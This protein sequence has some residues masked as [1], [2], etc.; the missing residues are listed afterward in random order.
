MEPLS[1]IQIVSGIQIGLTNAQ[2]WTRRCGA[3]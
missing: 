2:T 1:L 3:P